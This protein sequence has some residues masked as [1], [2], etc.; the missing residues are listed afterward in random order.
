M[1]YYLN[2]IKTTKNSKQHLIPQEKLRWL[3]VAFK[4]IWLIKI[5]IVKHLNEMFGRY[6]LC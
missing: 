2:N 1:V 4:Y 5:F 3:T 6:A